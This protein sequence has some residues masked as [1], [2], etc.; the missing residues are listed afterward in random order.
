MQ[1]GLGVDVLAGE[2]ERRRGAVRAASPQVTPRPPAQPA[3]R[4][5]QV[6]RG[7]DRVG[8]HRAEGAVVGL[9]DRHRGVRAVV[10]RG[11]GGGAGGVAVRLLQHQVAGPG[12]GHLLQHPVAVAEALLGDA[13]AETVVAVAPA[14]AAGRDGQD[15]AVLGVPLEAPRARVVDPAGEAALRVVGERRVVGAHEHG[16]G[17]LPAPAAGADQVAGL[18]VVV[19]LRGVAVDGPDAAGVVG[20]ERQ[21][22][23]ERVGDRGDPVG[24]VVGVAALGAVGDV[25]AGE[26]A[27]RVEGLPQRDQAADG[28]AD[29]ASGVV[30]GEAEQVLPGGQALRAPVGVERPAARPARRRGAGLDRAGGG[31]RGAH[32]PPVD[33]LG[34]HPAVRVPG[35]PHL[36]VRAEH[37]GHVTV[38]VV[39]DAGDGVADAAFDDPAQ[40]VPA[41]VGDG[42]G[43]VGVRDQLTRLV[44]PVTLA[45]AVEVGLP[46]QPAGRV[47]LVA[48]RPTGRIPHRCQS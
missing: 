36:R 23:G 33:R 37:G 16:A 42:A 25:L 4:L 47:V 34:H 5:D 28:P 46:A 40:R 19:P 9:R 39:L 30:V 13:P 35:E 43:G 48:P 8:D 17:E 20:G 11:R 29:L 41:V 24:G 1:A 22:A 21:V 12:E 44:V 6:G 26:P 10:P 18:V 15:H 27:G 31:V 3:A 14:V 2:G 32:R 7:A 38:G 45:T